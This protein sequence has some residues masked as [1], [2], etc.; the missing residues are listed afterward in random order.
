M[1]IPTI[2]MRKVSDKAVSDR[3]R[4]ICQWR[5]WGMSGKMT[6]DG[7]R[8]LITV[9]KTMSGGGMGLDLLVNY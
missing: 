7:T 9:V 8:E 2:W 6:T 1:E 3:A 4:V 5:V